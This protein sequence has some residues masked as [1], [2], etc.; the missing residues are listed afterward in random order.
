MS[1]RNAEKK[2]FPA[3]LKCKSK[4]FGKRGKCPENGEFTD[5]I[6][7]TC[8]TATSFEKKYFLCLEVA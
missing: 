8:N 1:C 3:A 7:K 2:N 4:C 5:N 6:S